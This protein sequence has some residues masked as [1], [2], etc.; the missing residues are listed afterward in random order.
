MADG[1]VERPGAVYIPQRRRKNFPPSESTTAQILLPKAPE[2]AVVSAAIQSVLPIHITPVTKASIVIRLMSVGGIA[3][4]LYVA[5][6]YWKHRIAVYEIQ[7]N[8]QRRQ[9]QKLKEQRTKSLSQLQTLNQFLSDR[10]TQFTSRYANHQALNSTTDNEEK[11]TSSVQAEAQAQAES[12]SVSPDLLQSNISTQLT[13]LM[14]QIEFLLVENLRLKERFRSTS[15]T[16]H[17]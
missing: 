11:S 6:R 16:D 15:T 14:N 4:L 3:L 17:G 13:H 10:I 2:A 8:I 1:F 7:L 12:D 9:L 5:F